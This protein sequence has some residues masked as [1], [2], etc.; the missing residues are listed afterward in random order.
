MGTLV[1]A[2]Q[3]F[4]FTE[5]DGGQKAG[6]DLDEYCDRFA[7][8]AK[9]GAKP[10]TIGTDNV[11][12]FFI[13]SLNQQADISVSAIQHGMLG[14]IVVLEGWNGTD[15]D[16]EVKVT[17]YN[18]AGLDGSTDGGVERAND[19][20]DLFLPRQDDTAAPPIA[21]PA[22]TSAVA[23]VTKKQLVAKFDSLRVRLI[24]PNFVDQRPMNFDLVLVDAAVVGTVVSAQGGL[25]MLDA[26]LVG[27][28]LRNAR[29]ENQLPRVLRREPRVRAG[30]SLDIVVLQEDLRLHQRIEPREL[31]AH[32]VRTPVHVRCRRASGDVQL[33]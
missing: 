6:L 19:G 12:G 20:N 30:Q 1:C 14:L 32:G 3:E 24:T 23:Y 17:L 22:F 2:A 9:A 11:L 16:D 18:V 25:Q 5:V 26:Q 7:C 31:A 15:S 21:K 33:R 10:R 13:A 4:R 8:E 27:P 28:K 29:V